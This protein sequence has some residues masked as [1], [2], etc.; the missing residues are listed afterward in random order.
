[1]NIDFNPMSQ[2]PTLKNG[3]Y[4]PEVLLYNSCDGYHLVHAF[5]CPVT[6]D[7]QHFA[8]FTERKIED[9]NNYK[10]WALLMGDPEVIK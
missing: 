5:F 4:C 2:K 10:A 9:A 7:F 8:D 6:G 1:M 3:D